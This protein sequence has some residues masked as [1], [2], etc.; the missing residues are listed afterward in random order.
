[1]EQSFDHISSTI[2]TNTT[3]DTSSDCGT[4]VS[5]VSARREWLLKFGQEQKS[6]PFPKKST[7]SNSN[8]VSGNGAGKEEEEESRDDHVGKASDQKLV[9]PT[10]P[11]R[12]NPPVYSTNTASPLPPMA[13]SSTSTANST[14]RVVRNYTPKELKMHRSNKDVEAT[15]E[16]YA[17]VA[18]LSQWL[19]GDPTSTKKKKHV[20]RG[21]NVINK[22]RT[23]EK[24]MENMI[25][26]EN[27]ISRGAVSDK[28]KWLQIAFREED[29]DD[30]TKS[31]FG[32]V[33][34]SRY[35]KS[36]V[37]VSSSAMKNRYLQQSSNKNKTLDAQS[38]IITDDAAASLSVKD[39]KDWL[40]NAFKKESTGTR[41]ASGSNSKS[42]VPSRTYGYPKAQTDIV[43]D[44]LGGGGDVAT[45]AKMRFKERSARKLLQGNSSENNTPIKPPA[46]EQVEPSQQVKEQPTEPEV[47]ASA[48]T[49]ILGDLNSASFEEDSSS[50]DF[51]AARDTLVTRSKK[52]GHKVQV[53]NKVYLRKNKFEKMEAE[54]RRKS[55]PHGLLKLSWDV[56]SPASGR[57]SNVYEKK[58]VSDIAPK[59]SFEEL[60]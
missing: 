28:K 13:A 31:E 60:P 33:A 48:D 57:P 21:R 10:T 1:M 41:V 16:G 19:A 23:F 35:A 42:H 14:R 12:H 15:D 55:G 39:K 50:V 59:K 26:V 6:T 4:E 38:E 56:A 44:R 47:E 37:A 7:S 3:S 18:K 54:N 17:S 24:D 52:N 8:G 29:D 51:R 40:R 30:D 22:S 45:R 43:H 27:H 20:R 25:I 2:S 53:V 58:F 5:S 32:S 34:S 11:P 9:A 46:Q 49:S 36:E